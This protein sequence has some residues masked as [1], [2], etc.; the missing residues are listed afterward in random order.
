MPDKELS[1]SFPQG[2]K[3]IQIV[4]FILLFSF[5][6]FFLESAF[7][8]N[9]FEDIS[10]KIL[11]VR[12]IAARMSSFCDEACWGD[13]VR[14][15]PF[16][17]LVSRPRSDIFFVENWKRLREESVVYVI[18]AG[19]EHGIVSWMDHDFSWDSVFLP[20]RSDRNPQ[21]LHEQN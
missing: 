21:C 14:C 5:H 12:R 15:M 3:C 19:F 13:S 9:S 17:F 10:S 8:M 1:P 11:S 4:H 7:A 18:Q 16:S 2:D 20:C 6:C